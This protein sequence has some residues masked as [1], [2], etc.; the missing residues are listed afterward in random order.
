MRFVVLAVAVV[1]SLW[2]AA[3]IALAVDRVLG[4]G[5]DAGSTQTVARTAAE[6]PAA[7]T[8]QASP[9]AAPRESQPSPATAP[10]PAG[11][12]DIDGL[13]RLRD[14]TAELIVAVEDSPAALS[15]QP[16]AQLAADALDVEAEIVSWQEANEGLGGDAEYFAQLFAEIAA[17]T[18]DFSTAPSASAKDRLEQAITRHRSETLQAGN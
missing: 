8:A 1:V 15:G 17:A 18:A 16:D 11:Q 7:T 10:V 9:E 3:V 13:N 5:D 2:P 14:D 6:P 4:G 12:L